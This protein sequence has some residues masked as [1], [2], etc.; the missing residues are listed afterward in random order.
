MKVF[1]GISGGVDSAVAAYLLKERGYEVTGAFMRNWDSASNDDYLGN[2]TINQAVCPQE[3]DYLDA[4]KVARQLDIPLL[5]IDYIKEYWDDV[6]S[7]LIEEYSLGRT[8]NP[9]I[10]CNKYIKFSRFYQFAQKN[11]FETLA[12]GHYAK[13][14]NIDSVNYLAKASDLSKDQ[15]YFLDQIDK[16]VLDHVIFPLQDI[17]KKEVREIAHKLGLSSVMDKKDSTGICFIGERNF[18]EFLKNYLPMK[19]GRMI[20]LDTKEDKGEMEGVF[21]YTIGQRKGLSIGG[22]GGP[23]FVAG[24]NVEKNLLYVVEKE[25]NPWLYSDSCLVKKVNWLVDPLDKGECM[26]KFRY[27]QNDNPV[28]FE[29]VGEDLLL[30][31][32]QQVKAVSPGQQAVLYQGD[33]CLGGG[34]IDS[35]YSQNENLQEKMEKFLNE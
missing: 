28:T 19:K 10:L 12:T 27:R 7:D 8:P 11:G 16:S 13:I 17:T 35:V 3:S 4:L 15:S 24:K 21:Y 14:A 6:F 1:I 22:E 9:D 2:P 5:R 25:D 23:W 33:I 26:A 29:R 18:K 30:K 31:Y 34:V 20:N 32:P